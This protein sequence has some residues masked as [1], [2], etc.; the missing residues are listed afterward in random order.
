MTSTSHF[1]SVKSSNDLDD[2]EEISEELDEFLNSSDGISK[3]SEEYTKD[4]TASE[5]RS[6]RTDY[7]EDV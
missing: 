2:A 3:A 4:E 6:L 7:A 5:G 1:S